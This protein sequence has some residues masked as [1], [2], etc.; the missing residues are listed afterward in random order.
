MDYFL[1][2]RELETGGK[3]MGSKV[4]SVRGAGGWFNSDGWG[5]RA[6]CSAP[7]VSRGPSSGHAA[8]QRQPVED[9]VE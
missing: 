2:P 8:V 3:V 9:A 4:G 1:S 5:R 6:S 7:N